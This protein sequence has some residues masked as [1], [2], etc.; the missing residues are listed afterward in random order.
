MA[1]D[2]YIEVS[3]A[4]SPDPV[5]DRVATPQ[6]PER[7]EVPVPTS[8]LLVEQRASTG[9]T[10]HLSLNGGSMTATESRRRA[11][12]YALSRIGS[13]QFACLD[14]LWQHE[15][16]WWYRAEN[17]SSGAYGIPQALP[18]TK[19]ASAGSDWR[20]NPITQVKWGLGYISGRYGSACRAWSFWRANGWY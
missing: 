10:A 16:G 3:A 11:K 12:S 7:P 8:P 14:P 18:G 19:M 13:A 15:S 2:A 17:R 4:P 20:T 5:I 9:P 6:P 1:E